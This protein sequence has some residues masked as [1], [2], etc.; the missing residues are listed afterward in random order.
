[1]ILKRVIFGVDKNPMA[2]ELAKVALWLH[3]FTVGAPLSFLDHHLKCGDSLHG[4]KLDS[5]RKGMQEL[6]VLFQD[7]ELARLDLAAKS[8]DQV[9][10][11]TDTSIAEAQESKSLADQAEREVEPIHALL[12]FWRALRWLVPGWP[13]NRLPK[14]K[15]ET[16]RAAI[17]ELF[18]GRYNLA[19]VAAS[20]SVDGDA[21]TLVA[22]N[23]LLGEA[24]TLATR[25]TFFH[26]WKAF[27]TVWRY[28]SE[29][30][31][32]FDAVIGNPPWDRI[33]LQKVEWFA[34]R[35]MDIARQA[36]AADRKTLIEKER[37]RRTPLWADYVQAAASAEAMGRVVR[38][39]GEY[40]LL[41]GGDVN[42]YSLFVERASALVRANGI[43]GLLT[44][45]G[46]AA[47]K[48]ASEFFR[49]I[50]APQASDL[51]GDNRTRWRRCTTLKI[52]AT[53]VAA[54]FRMSI[55][56]SN[57]APS[58][59][60]ANSAALTRRA[61]RFSCIRSQKCM[62]HTACCCSQLRTSRG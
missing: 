60:A 32:G 21:P 37:K 17:A 19:A 22:L 1:M 42:L 10:E 18:S 43:V 34:E 46:I 26:W 27:P 9:A 3:T 52:A 58:F 56:D 29:A 6:G 48:G 50:T 44:P 8:L 40:P 53:R 41:S 16:Q 39:S 57:S 13:T 47:D 38:E 20:G 23:I 25:E 59:S 36:R 12:S 24:R 4:E 11:L 14:I 33:K 35:K 49:S 28:G 51:F 5:V 30:D 2:V 55:R 62:T 15:D 7:A 31:G 61:V 45:S 54:T